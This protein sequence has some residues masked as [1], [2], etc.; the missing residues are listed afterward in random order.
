V[1]SREIARHRH[2]IM[3]AAA[4]NDASSR[5]FWPAA[6][7]DV[8]GVAATG[9]DGDL[10]AFSNRGDWVDATAPGVDVVSS[11]VRL[12]PGEEGVAPGTTTRVY[13]AARWSGT[14]FAA[15]RIAAELAHLRHQGRT[16]DEARSAIRQPL[17][18]AI[19]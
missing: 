1:L 12:L 14:S 16:V 7:P 18:R 9:P 19:D 5:P 11:Y 2:T 15:P 4:G 3:V 6:L 10:A 13:G 17:V 8:I